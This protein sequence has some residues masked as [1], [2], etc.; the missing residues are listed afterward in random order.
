MSHKVARHF[1][2]GGREHGGGIG[3]LVGYIVDEAERHGG[4]HAITDTRGPRLSPFVSPFRLAVSVAVIARD[5]ILDPACVQ[6]VHVA[7]RGSTVRKL[8]LTAVLR[9]VGSPHVL[10]LHD[11]DYADDLTRRP[12]W[13]QRRIRSMFRGASRVVTLGERDRTTMERL[14]GVSRDRLSVLH[15]AVPDPGP[16]DP[17]PR[18]SGPVRLLFLG[19]LSERK[20]VPELLAALAGAPMRDLDWRAVLAGDGPVDRFREQAAAAGI[21]DR[22]DMPGWVDEAEVRRLCAQADILVLPSHA[23]GLAMAV[24]EG[25]AHGLT[26]VTTRV[27]A[28]EEVLADEDSGV[29]VPPGDPVA[30]AGALAALAADP[31]RRARLARGARRRFV[32][33]LSIAAYLRALDGL[34]EGVRR[35]ER[36]GAR[37][38]ALGQDRQ[39]IA[40]ETGPPAGGVVRNASLV[41]RQ[42]FGKSA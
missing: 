20:G 12:A 11:P 31:A 28:H 4:A 19:R 34:Y 10:H 42:K 5:R 27:G 9:A 30:L 26:V 7:G 23:E 33:H 17:S 21:G 25:M 36:R 22:V 1:L 6:H 14:L 37:G 24:V 15:N 40:G 3:R 35:P 38:E 41:R 2:P 18:A 13:A 32:D 39:R 8:V 29:F 16:P